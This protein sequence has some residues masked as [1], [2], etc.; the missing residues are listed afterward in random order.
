MSKAPSVYSVLTRLYPTDFRRDFG[1]DLVQ[2]FNDLSQ[3]RGRAAAWR[4]A[5]LDLLVTVPR[6]RLESIM[7]TR[8]SSLTLLFIPAALAVAGAAS[9][10]TGIAP[11]AGL[12]L[13]LFGVGLLAVRRSDIARSLRI[14]TPGRNQR[15]TRLL[16][17][18]ACAIVFVASII[19]YM[20]AIGGDDDID[21]G[22][23]VA[24]N[25]IG[26]PSMIAAVGFLIA[27][28]LAPRQQTPAN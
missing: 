22:V 7:S 21:G 12:V 24:Y 18:A 6:Y 13:L 11:I 23:L 25:A 16:I 9:I 8:S 10:L 2:H 19:G 4:R 27:G 3:A 17:S 1:P 14:P 20:V 15:R 28:L 5:S 26:V